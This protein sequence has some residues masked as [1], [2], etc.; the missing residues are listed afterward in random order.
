VGAIHGRFLLSATVST[1]V[2]PG[3]LLNLRKIAEADAMAD[4]L[5]KVDPAV[6]SAKF[7]VSISD[8]QSLIETKTL[9]ISKLMTI[10]PPGTIDPSPFLYNNTMY[11]MAGLVSVASMLHFLVRPVNQKYFERKFELEATTL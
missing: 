5:S 6:F 7:G 11:T 1:I 10:M 3:L 4:M 2:G 9:T 8:A